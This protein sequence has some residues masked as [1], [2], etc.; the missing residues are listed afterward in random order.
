MKG[1]AVERPQFIL[2]L[3]ITFPL[4]A[5]PDAPVV[6]VTAANVAQLGQ[7][8]ELLGPLLVRL[9][10]LPPDMVDRLVSEQEPTA[11]DMAQLFELLAESPG[12]LEKFLAIGARLHLETVHAL[13]PDVAAYLFAV[14]CQVNADFFARALPVLRAAA[15]KLSALMPAASRSTPGPGSSAS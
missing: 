3:S 13:M 15:G 2:P 7:M 4:G 10:E 12:V 14:V 9:G 6:T 11:A 1:L 5:E 8:L